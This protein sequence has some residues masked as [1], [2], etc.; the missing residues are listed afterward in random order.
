MSKTSLAIYIFVMAFS[1]YLIRVIP[2]LLIRDKINNRFFRSFLYYVPYA[3]LSAM[4]IPAVFYATN[5]IRTGIAG[6]V[7]ALVLSYKEMN[8]VTVACVSCIVALFVELLIL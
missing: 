1:T 5:D 2:L 4:V 8:M 6:F 3:V 7:T